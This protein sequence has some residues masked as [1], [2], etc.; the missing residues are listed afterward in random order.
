[1]IPKNRITF[2]VKRNKNTTDTLTFRGAWKLNK[3]HEVTYAYLEE[4]LKT[5]RK[6]SRTLTFK[7]FW[8]I[9]EKNRLTYYFQ[10]NDRSY[11]RVRGAFQTRSILAKKGEIRYQFGIELEKRVKTKTLVLFGKWKFSHKL[12]LHFDIE[13]KRGKRH[14]IVFGGEYNFD[15]NHKIEVNLKG[16]K[17][18]RLGVELVLTRDFLKKDGKAFIRLMRSQDESKIEGGL[19]FKW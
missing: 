1:L 19:S 8:D 2:E 5:K 4:I 10:R 6:L 15:S 18:E 3:N 12:G 14:A 17:G 11:F 7:G 9:S 13:Y 16:R